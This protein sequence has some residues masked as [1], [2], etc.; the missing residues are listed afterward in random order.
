[1]KLKPKLVRNF[2]KPKENLLKKNY[3]ILERLRKMEDVL[4]YSNLKLKLQV[5]KKKQQKPFQ[6]KILSVEQC[7]MIVRRS[8]VL[9]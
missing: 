6:L 3:K 5:R 7:F 8:K 4:L 2:L 1:M 9:P